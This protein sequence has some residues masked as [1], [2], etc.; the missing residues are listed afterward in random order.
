MN[1]QITLSQYRGI[2]MFILA[3][4]MCLSQWLI[5]FAATSLYPGEPYVVS[6][7][8]AV[9]ALVMMRWGVWAAIHAALGGVVYAALFNGTW[10]HFLIYGLG[11]LAGLGAMLLFKIYGK[12]R[13]RLSAP[14]TLVFALCVQLL[15]LLGRAAVQALLGG[16]AEECFGFITTDILSALFCMVICWCIRRI[17]GLFEDQK[18]YLLRIER[19]RQVEGRDQF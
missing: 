3:A 19:E 5:S 13:I 7:V 10:Q 14:L 12:E 11:N 4:V 17:E 16:S 1:K 8:A 15:M 18:N 6:P 9:V 2:D